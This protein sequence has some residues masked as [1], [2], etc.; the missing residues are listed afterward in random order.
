MSGGQHPVPVHGSGSEVPPGQGRAPSR[1]SVGPGAW[2][3]AGDGRGGTAQVVL[4]LVLGFLRQRPCGSRSCWGRG[5]GAGLLPAPL[6]WEA[7]AQARPGRGQT[8]VLWR[9]A[10]E[11]PVRGLVL[12]SHPS[13]HTLLC[14]GPPAGHGAAPKGPART[15]ALVSTAHKY[16]AASP[17]AGWGPEAGTGGSRPLPSTSSWKTSWRRRLCCACRT[18]SGLGG[19]WRRREGTAGPGSVS[20]AAD[21]ADVRTSRHRRQPGLII[22]RQP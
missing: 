16:T 1:V 21:M 4:V 9:T 10:A 5:L 14:A 12:N 6:A 18:R 20:W 2:P 22:C 8:E 7:P 15:A 11:V 19:A 17:L 3:G 13:A